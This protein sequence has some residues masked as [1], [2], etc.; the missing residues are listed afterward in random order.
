MKG[1]NFAAIFPKDETPPLIIKYRTKIYTTAT[2]TIPILN[3][4]ATASETV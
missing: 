1:T 3:V 2:V 4:F